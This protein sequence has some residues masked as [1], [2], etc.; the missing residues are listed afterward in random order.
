MFIGSL[1]SVLA[2]PTPEVLAKSALVLRTS[3]C[4]LLGEVSAL[5]SEGLRLSELGVR[6]VPS[7]LL[8]HGE[9]HHVEQVL[10]PGHL[11]QRYWSS[12]ECQN[13][14]LLDLLAC[15]PAQQPYNP[16]Y[17]LQNHLPRIMP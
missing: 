8:A 15:A 9:I 12:C 5:V 3:R 11:L 2:R 10:N 16:A 17:Y 7:P 1:D 14:R 4:I 13:R 6:Q